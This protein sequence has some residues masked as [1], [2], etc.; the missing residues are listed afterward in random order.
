MTFYS[1][2]SDY[3]GKVY[4]L[5][6]TVRNAQGADTNLTMSGNPCVIETSS[7]KLFDPIK[8]RSCS[9][10]IV[11]GDWYFQLYE[12]TSRGTTVKVYEYDAAYEHGVKKVIFRGYLTPASY[13]QTW[14]Y[15]DAITLEAV[16][17]IS[18]TKDFKW[19]SDGTY[20]TFL[21]IILSILQSDTINGYERYLYVPRTYTYINENYYAWGD[22]VLD[23]LMS[24]SGN[25]IDDDD[26][27]TPWTHYDI[28]EEIMKFLGWSLV[29]DGD[30]VWLIDYRAEGKSLAVNYSVYDIKTGQVVV[31]EHGNP[32]V[33][34]SEDTAVNVNLDVL[35]PGTTQVSIDDVYNK[36]EISDNLYKIDEIS[37]DIFD[38]GYHIN[39]TEE[40]EQMDPAYSSLETS[41]WVK[42]Q[43]KGILFWKETQETTQGWYYQTLCR[44]NDNSG[45]THKYYHMSNLSE[46]PLPNGTS[47][48]DDRRYYDSTSSKTYTTGL[49]NKWVK[50][51]CALIQHYAF[52]KE[53]GN[54]MLP[55]TL[56][57]TD[58]LT[59]FVMDDSING[60]QGRINLF[61]APNYEKPVLEYNID[62]E[63]QWKPSSGTSFLYIKGD[64]F[65]QYNGAKYGEKKKKKNTLNTINT[66]KRYIFTAPVD[67]LDTIPDA[68][69]YSLGRLPEHPDYGKGFQMWKFRLQVGD[70]Y[71]DGK[72]WVYNSPRDFY[73]SYNNDPDPNAEDDKDKNEYM[74]AFKW[75]SCLN[76]NS[77]KD[78][79]GVDGYA[80]PIKF[81]DDTA[82]TRGK[83]KL[84]MYT[85]AIM[86]PD[87]IDMFRQLH[88]DSF[89]AANWS[90][91]CPVIFAKGVEFGYI[92]TDSTVWW[93]N[94]ENND[95]ADRVFTG[96][97]NDNYV[98]TFDTM[99]M[100]INTTQKDQPISRS[101]VITKLPNGGDYQYPYL[102]TMKHQCGDNDKEQEFN[103]VD[104]YLDH[105]SERKPIIEANVHGYQHP[106]TKYTKNYI[107]GTF[108]LDSQSWNLRE[109]NN[110]IKII[111]F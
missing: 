12:P 39:V 45:W 70:Y 82:P 3:N 84:T 110:R 1:K 96:N 19:V 35:A 14:T 111:S 20:K 69:L 42:T 100:R 72:K 37:P 17:A 95:K 62:E 28:L 7:S 99:Q 58:T 38:D 50:S 79:V 76:N 23:K 16:D 98:K 64:L 73:I 97:I 30:N 75:V 92:Y 53:Q 25:F 11:T 94:H 33:Y 56:D 34:T 65:Y 21:D 47:N 36:I 80:I 51:H 27:H 102:T 15:K 24:S 85:P 78:K 52:V 57:W 89:T 71:W 54:N 93:N 43:T 108:V 18:T 9:L 44:L 49:I 32:V 68:D 61:D 81:D 83:L 106:T 77:Y 48:A 22:D 10:E 74:P 88:L 40:I 41:K 13:D 2:F 103:V 105:H 87:M 63:I 29:P 109:N 107:D 66:D 101:Y 55:P 26:E 67:K 86:S 59:F 104:A 90:D 6:M 60:G 4:G 46:I 31:D 8:S 5:E 91:L